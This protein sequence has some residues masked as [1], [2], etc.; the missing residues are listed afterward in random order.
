[1]RPHA[2]KLPLQNLVKARYHAALTPYH[3]FQEKDLYSIRCCPG[4]K[5]ILCGVKL[6]LGNLG[7]L[8]IFFKWRIN[9]WTLS[10]QSVWVLKS[11]V[12]HCQRGMDPVVVLLL[13][14][15]ITGQEWGL[16]RSLLRHSC[17][18]MM[19]TTGT[20]REMFSLVKWLCSLN[21]FFFKVKD[22]F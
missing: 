2:P 6:D 5:N 8:L 10:S 1:M 3:V 18:Q 21:F 16:I 17:S 7:C 11:S 12:Q 15:S 13:L 20:S 22:G 9:E 19:W 4:V 14:H